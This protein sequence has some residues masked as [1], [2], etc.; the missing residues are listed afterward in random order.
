MRWPA[1]LASAI[2]AL[3]LV[4]VGQL[5]HASRAD[6]ATAGVNLG[7]AGS[8]AALGGTSVTNTGLSVLSGNV[9][10]SPA[11]SIVGFPP[12]VITGT[13]HAGDAAAAQ[14]RVDLGVGIADAA[15]RTP[16]AQFAG[17]LNGLTFTPGVYHSAAAMALTGTLTL[18]AQGDPTAVFI[19]QVDAALN[20]AAASQVSLVNGAS[21]ANVYWEAAGA[22]GTGAAS[23]FSGTIMTPAAIT[24]GAGGSLNGRAL[25]YG[26]VTLGDNVVTPPP[27]VTAGSLSISVPSGPVSLGSHADT[28]SG[29]TISGSLG[30][31]QVTDTRSAST[32]WTV[33][34]SATA[35]A[36]VSGSSIPASAMG[37]AVG[38]VTQILGVASYVKANPTSLGSA[39][40][41]LTAT[42]SGS[43]AA[44][45]N[46]TISVVVPGGTAAGSYTTTITHS[47]L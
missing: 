37:Y 47:V 4:L 12:G 8:Y 5:S 38:S 28:V 31:V 6:A 34:V 43:N 7:T 1:V 30:V 20:T 16:I 44:S 19:F 17:D 14:A 42:A 33:S 3:P 2:L 13:F 22:V 46:P 11:A 25:A 10:T 26:T 39:A 40:V 24:I 29:E 41:A 45:W 27:V 36:P 9:G 15:S 32:G 18:D 35:L 23:S 21:A